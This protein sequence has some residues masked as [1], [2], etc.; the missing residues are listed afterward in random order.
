MSNVRLNALSVER[1]FRNDPRF[2]LND[3]ED[4]YL[5][6]QAKSGAFWTLRYRFAERN[7]WMTLGHY[8]DMN[9][10]TARAEARAKRILLDKHQDPLDER[11]AALQ[12]KR[13]ANNRVRSSFKALADEWFET[14][15]RGRIK[16]P[17][18][19]QRYITKHLIPAFGSK[20]CNLLQVAAGSCCRSGDGIRAS[21]VST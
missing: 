10:A 15:I 4:L 7:R 3:G 18:V 14:E 12:S 13:E 6:K 11:R 8:P 16:H 19:P 5:R 17:Q 1:A 9:L 20:R 21:A 2:L